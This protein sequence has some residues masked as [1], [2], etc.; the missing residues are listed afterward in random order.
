MHS[1]SKSIICENNFVTFDL[2]EVF[3]FHKNLKV[4]AAA[5]SHIIDSPLPKINFISY[6]QT[7]QSST[8]VKRS[9]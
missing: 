4:I 9:E 3:E 7:K 6:R 5:K 2:S 8:H 1:G